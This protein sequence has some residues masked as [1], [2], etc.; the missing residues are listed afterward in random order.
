MGRTTK[1]GFVRQ[2]WNRGSR[3]SFAMQSALLTSDLMEKRPALGAEPPCRIRRRIAVSQG[4]DI[5]SVPVDETSAQ[6]AVNALEAFAEVARR[7]GD[8]PAVRHNGRELSYQQLDEASSAL[9]AAIASRIGQVGRPVGILLE[10]SP[11]MIVAAL[12]VVKAGACYVP[13]DPLVPAGRI[14][15]ILEEATPSLVI[16]SAG[17][18]GTVPEGIP[19]LLTDEE[20][21]HHQHAWRQPSVDGSAP[22]Y[23][24]FTSG[25]TGRPKG[26]RVSHA[27][28]L[29]LLASSGRAFPFSHNDVWTMFHS[30]GFD[31]A[32]WE[33]WAPLLSGG[34]LVIVP[35]DVARDPVEFRRLLRD[36]RVTVL[37]QTPKAF[38]QL[39]DEDLRHSDR[40][41]L[42][43]VLLGGEA[44][45]F[46]ALR[47]WV[48]KYGDDKP[49][50]FNIYGPSEATVIASY[51]PLCREDLDQEKS[52]IGRPLPGLDFVLV[53][54]WLAPV[55]PGATGEIVITGP[56]VAI[57][58]I[59]RD[60]LTRDRF[61]E[62]P[63]PSGA[64]VRGYRTG[65]LARIMDGEKYEYRGRNDDQVKIRGYR[66]E[67]GEVEAA[68]NAL[69]SVSKAAVV[70]GEL[71][72]IGMSLI[73]YVV[74]A[75]S[76]NVSA[77]ALRAALSVMFPEYMIPRAFIFLDDL[78]LT[79]HGK[80][81]R[82]ALPH[83][84]LPSYSE[85]SNGPGAD[86][87]E[88]R[89][90]GIT[91]ALLHNAEMTPEAD[92]FAAGGH[93]LLA[94]RLLARIRAELG[95]EVT[96]RALFREPTVRGLATAV[97]QARAAATADGSTFSALRPTRR[98]RH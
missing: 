14:K 59:A 6:A 7:F 26:A 95:A 67:P 36:E 86:D 87:I 90:L 51:Y 57:G 37:N 61:V 94:N 23:V 41:L 47:P 79:H 52:I 49:R 82:G 46:S 76:G 98:T 31:F 66:V 19:V 34:C 77:A 15:I 48:A 27:S 39:N 18:S 42:R 30:F 28:L 55:P 4:I 10:R 58:Y 5:P 43:L 78:P 63:S 2:H 8:R 17:H 74:G 91:R 72:D 88:A 45:H 75:A 85:D 92:F 83:P 24:I 54:E 44:L 35:H 13:L 38:D 62:V 29:H 69:A 16:T 64:V 56:S 40:L 25:T 12:A 53:D 70:S 68:L 1:P 3:S 80:L 93:S 89:L 20:P 81:D 84:M 97:R 73:A 60:D 33:T 32:I 65:D 9:A 11:D 96:L 22:M 21:A 71:P 50:L